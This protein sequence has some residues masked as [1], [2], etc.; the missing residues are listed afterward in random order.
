VTKLLSSSYREFRRD[1]GP[2]YSAALAYYGLFAISP[3]LL[4]A[5]GVA[6]LVL[7]GAAADR[8]LYDSLSSALGVDLAR[9]LIQLASGRAIA[10]WA[11]AVWAGAAL[12]VAASV[13]AMLKTQAACN[14]MWHIA[15]RRDL[16]PARM[17]RVRLLTAVVAL[18]PGLLLVL[19]A[20]ARTLAGPLVGLLVARAPSQALGLAAAP[21][22][23]ALLLLASAILGFLVLFALLPDAHV[24]LRPAITGAVVT[25]I[26][27]SFGTY[28]FGLYAR[29]AAP[30]SAS[31]AAG[32]VFVLLTWLYY[33]A[34]ITLIGWKLTRLLTRREGAVRPR[35]YAEEIS[36]ASEEE[37]PS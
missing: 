20:L 14:R 35:N 24:P 30:A 6:G 23:S 19:S 18:V 8:A 2:Y 13:G 4:I 37:R 11:G 7:R 15:P 32:M 12:T 29:Y 1:D 3:A 22:G 9:G 34:Q 26:A 17:A 5:V 10:A 31:G 21:A 25:G 36:L 33:S 16:S 28:L 27:W